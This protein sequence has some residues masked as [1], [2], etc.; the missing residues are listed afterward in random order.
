M[1]IETTI[2]DRYKTPDER[3]A[4]AWC[5]SHGLTQAEA[6]ESMTLPNAHYWTY[7]H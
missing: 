4:D 1:T 2:A 3:A 5:E 6:M 7:V